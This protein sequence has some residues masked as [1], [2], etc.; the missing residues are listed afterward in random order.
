MASD[1]PGITTMAEVSNRTL[2]LTVLVVRSPGTRRQRL[3]C[4]MRGYFLVCRQLSSCFLLAQRSLGLYSRTEREQGNSSSHRGTSLT[5]TT[6]S[7]SHSDPITS[8]KPTFPNT[9]R[10][11][12]KV[13]YLT[14][15]RHNPKGSSDSTSGTGLQ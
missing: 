15:E 12:L 2:F 7:L 10:L 11:R 13:L 1:A 5:R 4:L 9:T 8:R 6:P 14:W 3:P